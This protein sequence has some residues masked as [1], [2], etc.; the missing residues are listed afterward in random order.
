MTKQA[1]RQV[2]MVRPKHFGYDPDTARSNAFQQQGKAG[3]SSNIQQQAL[4]EFDR[5]VAKLREADIDVLVIEDT[6]EPVKPNAIFPNNWI[7]LHEDGKAIL[8]PMLV[9]NRRRERRDDI[10]ES[11]RSEGVDIREVIDLSFY[12]EEEKY[13]ESTGSV[14]FDY[15]HR[16]CYACLSERTSPEVLQRLSE[17]TGDTPIIFEA[18]D[19]NGLPIY[20]TNVM[21]CIGSGYAVICTESIPT[22]QQQK[23]LATLEGTGHEIVAIT[24]DQMYAFAGNMLELQNSQGEKVLVLS[25]AA[26]KSL[27]PDQKQALSKHAQLLAI[28]IP[29]IEKYG[30]GSVRCMMC[31][32]N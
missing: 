30:G 11:L 5:M 32:V 1:C 14:I 15:E 23:V 26:M 19:K 13:L 4:A 2:M 20:H 10:L 17:I 28:P 9:T 18:Y 8:Y 7:S 29:T 25:A 3:D 22:T 31:R 27:T 16:Q 6:D 24:L 21:M 12:E